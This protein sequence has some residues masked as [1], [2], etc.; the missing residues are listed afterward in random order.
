M[1]DI[2]RIARVDSGFTSNFDL[3]AN[4]LVMSSLKLGTSELTKAKLDLIILTTD[5]PSAVDASAQHHHDGRY[6][7]ETELGSTANGSSG[8]SLIG[9]DQTPAFTNISGADAQALFESIDTALNTAGGTDFSDSVFR[10]SDNGDSSKKI[11]FEASGITTSTVRTITMPDADVT[12]G[13]IAANKS[14]IADIRT[15]TGTSDGDTDM[16]SYTGTIISASGTTKANIQELE[17]DLDSL[18]SL[19]GMSAGSTDLSTF[20]GTTIPDSSTI[21]AALQSLETKAE[22]NTA[23]INNLEWQDSALDYVVDNTAVPASEVTGNRYILS[24]DGGAP[25]ANYDGA[26]AG[27]IVEFNGTTWD[28]TTPTTGMFI[29]ADDET[30]L[31]YYW[32]G[33][34]WAT[35]DF[36]A[37]TASTG[38]TKVGFDIRL[39]GGS[40]G[41]GLAFTAG[42][43]SVN[44][45]D[46]GIEISADT[47]QLKNGGVTSAKLA[48][49]VAGD[50]IS[51]GAGTALALDINGIAS[52]ETAKDNADLI[53]IYD[54]SATALRKMTRANFIG[55]DLQEAETFFANTDISGAEAETLT[56]GSNA[57]S[58]HKHTNLFLEGMVNNTGGLLAAGTVV[59]LSQSTPGEIIVADASTIATG[60]GVIGILPVSIADTASGRVQIAG[61]ISPTKDGV[62]DLGKRVY[63]SETAGSSSKTAPTATSTV[64]FVLGSAK[65]TAEIVLQPHLVGVN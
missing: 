34:S 47:L 28:A 50:G 58:L 60:E 45:D 16:G 37:T 61:T 31:L 3:S 54:D 25:H 11:A 65:S 38:L 64:V 22:A 42:V 36:E 30:T 19:S 41:D 39:A 10:I 56:D 43:L 14:D 59:A 12:L 26:S 27:D 57:D 32:G 4:T 5:S 6:F 53:A 18:Q 24:H 51:G 1:A 7:T 49:A 29:S 2:S 62:Y 9:I 44:V 40:A 23:L 20:S 48:A 63:L 17:T 33:A 46:V 21:K 55:S 35:K 52:A 15:T 13:D 8:A